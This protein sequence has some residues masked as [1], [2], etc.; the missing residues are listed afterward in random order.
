MEG[1]VVKGLLGGTFYFPTKNELRSWIAGVKH[2]LYTFAYWKDG[3]MYV[4]ASGKTYKEV[5]GELYSQYREATGE[6]YD[7]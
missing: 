7:E 2:A 3:E 1:Y 6:D 5:M 4:G